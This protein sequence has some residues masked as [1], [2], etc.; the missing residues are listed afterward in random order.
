MATYQINAPDGSQYQI[1]G[2]E[3]VDPSA[4]IQQVTEQHQS[5][6]PEQKPSVPGAN[7]VE[8]ALHVGSQ[9]LSLP[10]AAGASL[11]QLITSPAGMKAANAAQA[12]QSVQQAM[13][14]QPRTREGSAI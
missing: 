4:V 3:G 5:A 1:E 7:I 13:T 6:A 8:P 12:A 9:M 10:V 2:P 14:Y 11:Y